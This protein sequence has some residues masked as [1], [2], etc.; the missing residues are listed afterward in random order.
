[1]KLI[2]I[3]FMIATLPTLFG[4][5]SA[6]AQDGQPADGSKDYIVVFKDKA[7]TRVPDRLQHLRQRAT[8]ENVPA[9]A[10]RLTPDELRE[11]RAHPDVDYVAPDRPLHASG[12]LIADTINASIVWTQNHTGKGVGIAVIDS[13]IN[14]QFQ[15][16][17]NSLGQ[18]GQGYS[19]VVY[20]ENFLVPATQPNG[21]PNPDRY[22][23][24]DGYGHGTH[25]AGIIAG[26]G[27][28]SLQTGSIRS[29]AGIAPNAN[30]IDL[31]VLDQ[32]G[33][34]SDSTVI[35][36]INRAISLKNTYN[37]RVINLSLGRPI[38]THARFYRFRRW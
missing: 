14:S 36:A 17:G 33:Q 21:Q 10:V 38:F 26:N 4:Q 16:L 29:I 23:T 5:I 3:E 34:G 32:N 18:T 27:Y 20:A 37:I 13:G 28:L 19:R 7:A 24:K 11:L 15:D 1:V 9:V 8:Y 12:D 25:V 30:L 31:Q 2:T 22:H 6:V 35:A